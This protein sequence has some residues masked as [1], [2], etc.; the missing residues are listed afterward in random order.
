MAANNR[1]MDTALRL[2]QLLVDEEYTTIERLSDG[3]GLNA[4]QLS[5]AVED[6]GRHLMMPPDEEF[7]TLVHVYPVEGAEHPEWNIDIDLWTEEEGQSDLTL[8]VNIV[9]S[10]P[11]QWR[12]RIEDLHVL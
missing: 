7:E 3:E 11:A 9:E 5:E 2:T 4:A 1:L 10:A 8:Q 6:Y 12:L